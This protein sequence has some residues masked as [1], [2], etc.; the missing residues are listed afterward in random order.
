MPVAD[1]R[2]PYR[3]ETWVEESL[4]AEVGVEVFF[5]PDDRPVPRDFYQRAKNVCRRCEVIDECFQYS[6]EERYGVWAA[7]TPNERAKLR[8][9]RSKRNP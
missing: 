3:P 2:E 9:D 4:C 6:I 1:R 8:N 7:T 5:P